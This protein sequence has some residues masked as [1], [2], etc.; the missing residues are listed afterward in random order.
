M[1]GE[2]EKTG[3]FA[4]KKGKITSAEKHPGKFLKLFAEKHWIF[5]GYLL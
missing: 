5:P 3:W 1:A 4:T 2:F